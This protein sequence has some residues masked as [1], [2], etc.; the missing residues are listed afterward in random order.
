MVTI[1]PVFSISCLIC[2]FN[3]TNE[4]PNIYNP[5]FVGYTVIVVIYKHITTVI[6]GKEG[7]IMTVG[8]N[9]KKRREE[10]GLSQMELASA[11]G[12]GQSYLSQIE[13]G[14]KAA[15]IQLGKEIA[16]ILDC[17]LDDLA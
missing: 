12:V 9:I 3:P 7:K 14:T 1:Q 13:R 8:E 15:S 4:I 16:E 2:N 5:S 17:T 11:I 6:N 10:K